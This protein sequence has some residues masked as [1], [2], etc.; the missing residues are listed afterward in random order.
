MDVK[1]LRE[2]R[3]ERGYGV[4]ELCRLAGVNY[5]VLRIEQGRS[6]GRASTFR[7]LAD[8]L[9]VHITQIAEYRKLMGL[10]DESPARAEQ[11]DEQE[12]SAR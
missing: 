8:A 2:W 12:A 3:I 10:D 4:R 1:T 9:G 7:K 6:R 11:N 5:A